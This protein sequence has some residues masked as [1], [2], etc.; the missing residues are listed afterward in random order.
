MLMVEIIDIKLLCGTDLDEAV[1]MG[2][3]LAV[4]YRCNVRF[5]FNKLNVL[6][7][8]NSVLSEVKSKYRN[9]LRKGRE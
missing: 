5:N 6:I 1:K 8:E 2:K 4:R 7:N 9:E 3:I